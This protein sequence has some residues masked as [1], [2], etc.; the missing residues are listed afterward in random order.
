[1]SGP[2]LEVRGLRTAFRTRA[3]D[4]VALDDVSFSL[5]A[6]ETLALVG[7]SGC[8]K[9]LTALSIMRLVPPPGRIASSIQS[10]SALAR[11]APTRGPAGIPRATTAAP[12]HGRRGEGCS[13]TRAAAPKTC[14]RGSPVWRAASTRSASRSAAAP[15]R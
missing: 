1:M 7:E 5:H 3:G 13:S 6:R 15:C 12:F 2:A 9:S 10:V 11:T 14:G 4:L 8:G